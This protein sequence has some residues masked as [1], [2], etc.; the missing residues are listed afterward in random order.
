MVLMAPWGRQVLLGISHKPE[1]MVN[2]VG[3]CL[4]TTIREGNNKLSLDISIGVL[5]LT[6]LEV[7]LGVVICNSI[8][9]SVGFWNAILNIGL[10][11]VA[12]GHE[13]T[14]KDNLKKE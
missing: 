6:L 7:C 11:A 8:L 14:G 10:L 9:V 12:D 3:G 4:D 1:D 2:S 13:D 5:T